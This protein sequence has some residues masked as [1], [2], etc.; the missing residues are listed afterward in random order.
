M[1]EIEK[2]LKTKSELDKNI[3]DNATVN[4]NY[5]TILWK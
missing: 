4:V 2:S 1:T 5:L 3:E